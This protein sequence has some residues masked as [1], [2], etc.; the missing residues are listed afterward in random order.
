MNLQVGL[1]ILK[2]DF[3]MGDFGPGMC[4]VGV[5]EFRTKRCN[6]PPSLKCQK[7]DELNC[8]VALEMKS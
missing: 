7:H 8:H 5:E 6:P 2:L 1:R 4:W 3:V